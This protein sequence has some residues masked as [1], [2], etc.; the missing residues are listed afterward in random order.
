[1]PGTACI[2]KS[3]LSDPISYLLIMITDNQESFYVKEPNV[4]GSSS[5]AHNPYLSGTVIFEM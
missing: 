3:W 4:I 5:T 1:M 2:T